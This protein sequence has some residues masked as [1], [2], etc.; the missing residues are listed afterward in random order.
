MEKPVLG[1]RAGIEH[2]LLLIQADRGFAKEECAR[3]S[4]L[5]MH[6][7]ILNRTIHYEFP[8]LRPSAIPLLGNVSCPAF[9]FIRDFSFTMN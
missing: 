8:Q 5:I 4:Y 7:R 1:F 2:K 6:Y 9:E 3:F